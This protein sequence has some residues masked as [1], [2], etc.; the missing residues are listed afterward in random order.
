MSSPAESPG[1]AQPERLG[2]AL[3]RRR[4]YRP[5]VDPHPPATACLAALIY[6]VTTLFGH[7]A[8]GPVVVATALLLITIAVV[9]R[10]IYPAV[11]SPVAS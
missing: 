1:R 11:A 8:L 2:G 7:G 3:G 10:R 4:R 6:G 9:A 5:R